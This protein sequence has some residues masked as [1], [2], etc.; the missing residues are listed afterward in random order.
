MDRIKALESLLARGPDTA[1]LRFSLGNA[2][3]Q[4][5]QFAEAIAH[6]QRATEIDPN[7]SAAWKLLGKA[8]MEAGLPDAAAHTYTEGIK[9][10]EQR[11]DV[12]AAKEM[13]VFLK[14]LQSR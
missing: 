5:G 1:L 3:L 9:V 14:R 13:R 4:D 12:Q 8:Q 6:L 10:A 7:Y 2:C 11:G